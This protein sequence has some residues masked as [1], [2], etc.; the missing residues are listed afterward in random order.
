MADRVVPGPVESTAAVREAVC[1]HTRKIYQT[2]RDKDCIEDLRVYLT[3]SSRSVLEGSFGVRPKS[4]ELILAQPTVNEV[5]FNRGYYTVDVTYYYKITGET[6]TSGDLI[7]GLSVFDKRVLLFGSEAGA[8][9]FSSVDDP[10]IVH[11]AGLPIAMVETVDPI[12]LRMNLVEKEIPCETE[13]RAIPQVVLDAFEDD[14]V[15][16][17][18]RRRVYVTLGQFSIIRL[19]RD[20]QL[21]IPA[22]DYCV[23]EQSWNKPIG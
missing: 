20:T 1:I 2:C 14:L 12:P 17:A 23:P 21:L 10:T 19:E 11:T 7:T 6:L 5:S 16:E 3:E 22:Y 4:A 9:V 15:F 8:K 13:Q 18:E